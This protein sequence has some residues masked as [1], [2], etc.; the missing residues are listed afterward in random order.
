MTENENNAAL[1]TLPVND[2][3]HSG[4]DNER[5]RAISQLVAVANPGNW[6]DIL[7]HIE[8]ISG[9]AT[10]SVNDRQTSDDVGRLRKATAAIEDDDLRNDLADICT[11]ALAD[12]PEVLSDPRGLDVLLDAIVCLFR[13]KARAALKGVPQPASDSY[14]AGASAPALAEKVNVRAE[15]R[16]IADCDAGTSAWIVYDPNIVR[17]SWAQDGRV[18]AKR[19]IRGWYS[20]IGGYEVCPTHFMPCPSPPGAELNFSNEAE[21]DGVCLKSDTSSQ[22]ASEAGKLSTDEV[23]A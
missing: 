7:L 22:P 13:D 12:A 15:W 11:Q 17:F 2:R 3:H 9:D 18:V 10:Q 5:L 8:R 16:L 20:C 14:Q 1:S 23:R 21:R 6:K 4:S 19:G